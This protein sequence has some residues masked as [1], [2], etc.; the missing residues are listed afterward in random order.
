MALSSPES[1]SPALIGLPALGGGSACCAWPA[2][3]AKAM[4]VIDAKASRLPN[5]RFVISVISVCGWLEQRPLPHRRRQRALVEIVKL[6]ADRNAVGEP[7]HLDIRLLQEVGDV[8]RGGLAI[9][10][11]IERQNDFGHLLF[12]RALDQR[13]NSEVL[14]A[15]AIERRQRRAQDVI[16]PL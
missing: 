14:R 1:T 4:V 15:D 6:A 9:N 2:G 7:R 16:A 12:M 3:A 10:R 5:R 11:C 13:I 8:M